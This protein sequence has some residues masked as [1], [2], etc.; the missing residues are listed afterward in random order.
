MQRLS[1]KHPE[2][3]RFP[4]SVPYSCDHC[5]IYKATQRPVK[6][7]RPTHVP[8]TKM[9]ECMFVDTAGPF[10]HVMTGGAYYFTIFV[11]EFSKQ[12]RGYLLKTKAAN[13]DAYSD[14]V[15]AISQTPGEICILCSDNAAEFA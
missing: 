3:P 14:F 15:I 8:A 7:S 2:L 1:L 12:G 9:W 6:T 10:R 4:A 13:Y 11:D 5:G